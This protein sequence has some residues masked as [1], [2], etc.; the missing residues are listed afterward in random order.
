MQQLAGG[1][2]G[3]FVEDAY[4]NDHVLGCVDALVTI[5]NKYVYIIS[6]YCARDSLMQ[7]ILME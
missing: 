6:P 3:G 4:A 5:D 2:T 7:Q 1:L